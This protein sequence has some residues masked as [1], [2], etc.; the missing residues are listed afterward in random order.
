MLRLTR[1]L[2]P[3]IL[4]IIALFALVYV[5]VM[6]DLTLPD[7]MSQIVNEG[8]MKSDTSI[9]WHN[10]IMMLLYALLG[11]V[12]N[13]GAGFFASRVGAGFAKDVRNAT[14]TK[15][16]SFSLAEFNRFSPAHLITCTTNDIQ[17]LQMILI[18][19][20]R[21]V[22]LAP[23]MG[24]GGILKI[25]NT[26]MEWI[27][28]VSVAIMVVA[29]V[30]LFMV[31]LPRFKLTQKL[32]DRL[33][34][35]TRE[36]LT[37]LRVIRAFNTQKHEEEKF[38]RANRDLMKV[39]LFVN[40]MMTLLMPFMMI[41]MNLTMVAIVWFGAK[42]IDIGELQVGDMMAF[43]QYAM[44]ILMAFLMT[45]M[46]FIILPRASVSAG[47]IRAVLDTEPTV[48]DPQNPIEPATAM[49]G[50]VE[51]KNVAF[52]YPGAEEP[53]L[54]GI[55]F[56]AQP[57]KTTA[58][59]GSTGSGKTT[60]INL[61]PRFY[62][63]TEGQ[64]LVDGVDV[65]A[66]LQTGVRERIGYVPQKG[67][68][69]SG[70]IASNISFGKIDADDAQIEQAAKTAQA[71]DFILEKEEKFETPIAQGGTNVSGGQRQR[72]SIARAL[73]KKPEIYIFDDSFSA[74]DYKTDVA[75]R[76]AL[77]DQTKD[78]TVIIVAQRIGTIKHADQII[79]LEQGRIV[80]LRH[81]RC[82]NAGLRR[83]SRDRIFAV[84]EG[85][86]GMSEQQNKFQRPP[87][88]RPG[89][90]FG[91]GGGHGMMPGEKAK[92]FKGTMRKLIQYVRPY[93]AQFI[94]VFVF[95]IASTV[96][97]IRSPKIMGE[98]TTEIFKGVMGKLMGAPNAAINFTAI[99]EII[100]TLLILYALSALFNYIQGFIMTGVGQKITYNLRKQICE[101]INRLPLKYFDSRTHGEVLSHVTNDV[102]TINTTLNQSLAQIVSSVATVIGV[103]YMMLTISPIMTVVTVL[104]VPLSTVFISVVVKK[105]QKY[106]KGQQD[107]LGHVNGHVEEMYSNHG[108]MKAFNAEGR[109]VSEFRKQNDVLYG[110]AWKANFLSG[111]MMPIISFIGNLGYVAVSVLGGYLAVKKTIQVGDIQS[112]IQYVRTFTQPLSQIAQV[113]N[114][115]QS[116]AAA[117]E[118]VFKLLEE[119]EEIPEIENPA[120][121]EKVR[122]KVE[123]EN[124][125]FGYAEDKT[126]IHGF[127]ATIAPGQRIAIVGPT[128]AGK[129]TMVNLLMRF[130]DVNS[131]S[132]KIDGVDVRDMKRS[133]LRTML[134]MVLQD[135]WL[136]NGTIR[137]NIA[138]GRLNASEKDIVAAAKAAHVDH[139]VHTFPEG[140]N[141]VLN[142]EANNISQGQKQLL[143]IARAV[144]ADPPVLILDEAT[145]S[146]GHAYRGADPA[147]NGKPDEGAHVVHHRA[148]PLHH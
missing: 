4:Q 136:F 147:G 134:G 143:T 67:S 105:S 132:I 1:F 48:V 53:V 94:V 97:A 71:L 73:V 11:V 77:W 144:L 119:P 61:I 123:F 72:L 14:F 121:L 78:A 15:V 16:E 32:I 108:V 65:R 66:M 113:A 139:F 125:V 8:I 20:L 111:M 36:I 100:V 45:T 130:Y 2:K 58:I 137:D 51:F 112:F 49:K 26:S 33:N 82:A 148:P 135:T 59:I 68:L 131:G 109:S 88:R 52:A 18:M 107:S 116:T 146:V 27:I 57:G 102:D 85:G 46:V 22:L 37:G 34:L 95:A 25:R 133:D 75:L 84:I 110:N 3:Y 86:T 92:D 129:T 60:L 99:G 74:L 80:G 40:R 79:V 38:D 101:K 96:F 124:V 62:D 19:L 140:Y 98:A 141:L 145:S 30:I 142:E 91:P 5:L 90:G 83:V 118:R 9:I 12:C 126:I 41:V 24:I 28:A 21:M 13:V 93:W 6:T 106:F 10:G 43:I 114:V 89:G 23:I 104:I 76:K 55:T 69:F 64:V 29:I 50:M 87:M 127:N 70:T 56:T 7:Y 47:R 117:A 103:L 35:V 54:S 128:G 138:Y 115:L 17:Q 63:A 31:A 42:R 81:A 44:L 122:G 39:Q 120:H